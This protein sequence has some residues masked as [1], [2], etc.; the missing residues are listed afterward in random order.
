VNSEFTK[1]QTYADAG[2]D[3]ASLL[4]HSLTV[5]NDVLTVGLVYT[6]KFRSANTV[7][8]SDYTELLRVGLGDIVSSPENLA[9]NFYLATA[10]SL[11]MIWEEVVDN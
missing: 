2:G 11:V 9:S 6:F 3:Q 8:W 4:S 1:V 10:T 5:T 7:G